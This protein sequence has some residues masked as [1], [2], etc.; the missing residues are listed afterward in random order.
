MA[1]AW[2][3]TNNPYKG[4]AAT[5]R[6]HR[7]QLPSTFAVR[8]RCAGQATY[9]SAPGAGT[10][11]Q[12]AGSVRLTWTVPPP[13]LAMD[14]VMAAETRPHLVRSHGVHYIQKYSMPTDKPIF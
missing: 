7:D 6:M 3:A 13:P 8:S 9:A 14:E 1:W 5:K 2:P 4:V 10:C 12:D 11:S